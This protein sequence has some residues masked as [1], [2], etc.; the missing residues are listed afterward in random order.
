LCASAIGVKVWAGKVVAQ[1]E[2]YDGDA[3]GW[4]TR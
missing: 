4:A 3:T 2:A 1:R